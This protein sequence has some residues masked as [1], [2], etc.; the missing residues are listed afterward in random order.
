MFYEPV[1][2]GPKIVESGAK[3]QKIYQIGVFTE[4]VDNLS[5]FKNVSPG[6]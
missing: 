6:V 3:L 1:L 5:V 4:K 2:Y